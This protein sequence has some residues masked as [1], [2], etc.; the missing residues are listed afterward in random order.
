MNLL[1]LED[2]DLSPDTAGA[3]V[4]GRRARHLLD[5]LRAE[6]GAHLVVGRLGGQIGWGTVTK[7]DD[8]RIHLDVELVTE[9]PAPTP[10]VLVV[11][12]PRPKVLRR[13]LRS[14]TTLG[15]KELVL[16]NGA[17]VEKSY[18][19]S[20]LLEPASIREQLLLGL[21]QAVDTVLPRVTLAPRFRPFVEDELPTLR[22][23][24]RGYLA[25][26]G[27]KSPLSAAAREPALVAIGPEGG[28]VPFELDLLAR[29]GLTP[30]GLG[31]RTLTSDAAATAIAS[32]WACGP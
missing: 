28:F 2:A 31:P 13:L 27:A 32:H 22:S 9:P 8:D 19:Q 12:L 3:T 14:L 29:A 30:I 6:P 1:I 7:V 24:R 23:G 10:L 25:H 16:T 21:E 26:P 18:F 15:I 4:T 11:A 17:R 5:V 20:P